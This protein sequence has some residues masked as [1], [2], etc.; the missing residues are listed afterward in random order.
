[1]KPL[2]IPIFVPNQGC[3]NFCVFCNQKKIT[4]VLHPPAPEDVR[5]IIKTHLETFHRKGDGSLFLLSGKEERST[6]LLR[7]SK[8][9]EAIS[10]VDGIAT[11]PAV[12]RNDKRGCMKGGL[13]G[14]SDEEKIKGGNSSFSVSLNRPESNSFFKEVAFYGGNFTGLDEAYQKKLLETAKDEID[15]SLIDGIRISTRPDYIDDKSLKNLK[16]FG[17]K[18]I[19][20]GVQSFSDVVLENS[21]RG[22]NSSSIFNAVELIRKFGFRLA[23]QLMM[24]LPGDNKNSLMESVEKTI[25]IRP[26]FVRIY[27]T[28]VL[29][30]TELAEFYYKGEYKALTLG[31]TINLGKEIL[32]RFYMAEIPVIRVGL[33]PTDNINLDKD[34]IAGPCHPSLRHIIDS[35]IA[36]E[37]MKTIIEANGLSGKRVHFSVPQKELSIFQGLLKENIYR[38]KKTCALEEVQIYTDSSEN[39]VV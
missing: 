34:V 8:A 3:P 12:A 35:E 10:L 25:D 15:K 30:D 1:V 31:E 6:V 21:K 16:S 22:H 27:P 17:V 18:T 28:L 33:Q 26:D 37:K 7:G 24:G 23:I 4:G 20:L 11:L 32:K 36:F 38:L 5:E 19:E 13:G 2:I 14:F 39:R 9:T 29:R